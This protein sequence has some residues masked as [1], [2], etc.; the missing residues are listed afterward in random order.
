MK[1]I[2][3]VVLAVF[4]IALPIGCGK[5]QKD[6][7]TKPEVTATPTPTTTATDGTPTPKPT[8]EPERLEGTAIERFLTALHNSFGEGSVTV[9]S[10]MK[11]MNGDEEETRT[12]QVRFIIGDD[13][14]LMFVADTWED[15]SKQNDYIFLQEHGGVDMATWWGNSK[16]N[17]DFMA[18][19]EED[20]GYMYPIIR[21][22]GEPGDAWF[23]SFVKVLA[24][25]FPDWPSKVI[26]ENSSLLTLLAAFSSDEYLEANFGYHKSDDGADL[27]VIRQEM[28]EKFVNYVDSDF[29]SFR[30]YLGDQSLDMLTMIGNPQLMVSYNG[31]MLD[32]IAFHFS[33]AGKT[34]DWTITFS[35]IGS[36]SISVPS[37]AQEKFESMKTTNSLGVESTWRVKYMTQ[38][39]LDAIEGRITQDEQM[40]NELLDAYVEFGKDPE[41]AAAVREELKTSQSAW[42]T[43]YGEGSRY[44]VSKIPVLDAKLK[45]RFGDRTLTSKSVWLMP[46]EITVYLVPEVVEDELSVYWD[47]GNYEE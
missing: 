35:E 3:L 10:E 22:L 43:F 16:M 33:V 20:A 13:G 47:W 11:G 1:R 2:I 12:K 4:L 30:W 18:V 34:A 27:F 6:N 5:Q 21:N 28:L 14:V 44:D 17:Y 19:S 31:A 37:A 38:F 24:H 42:A 39:Q 9:T 46:L 45:E 26:P 25:I 29:P 8:D 36:T 41:V 15:G 7:E 32:K 23:Q 40:L